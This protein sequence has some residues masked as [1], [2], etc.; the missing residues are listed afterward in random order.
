MDFG[1]KELW[2]QR[3]PVQTWKDYRIRMEIREGQLT[4]W[5]DGIRV[6]S[7]MEADPLP[8]G[9][10]GTGSFGARILVKRVKYELR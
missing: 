10:A 5:I 9:R 4:V 2:R 6:V 3:C 1:R 8:Y 7:V